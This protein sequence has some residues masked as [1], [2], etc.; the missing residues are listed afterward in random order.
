M[1]NSIIDEQSKIVRSEYSHTLVQWPDSRLLRLAVDTILDQKES[2]MRSG[3]NIQIL[4]N[5]THVCIGLIT[6]PARLLVKELF[7]E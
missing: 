7:L 6:A 5:A 1:T 4:D 3:D 2:I